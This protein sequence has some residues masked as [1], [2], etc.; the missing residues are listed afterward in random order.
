MGNFF[1]AAGVEGADFLFVIF[2]GA[3]AAGVEG[4]D[5]LFVLVDSALVIAFLPPKPP[6]R[7]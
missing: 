6:P 5:S 1:F 4:A 7:I 3:F 2:D